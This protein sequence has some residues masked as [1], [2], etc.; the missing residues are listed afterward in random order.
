MRCK[1]TPPNAAS[2][3]QEL[4]RLSLFGFYAHVYSV[5]LAT[6]RNKLMQ[7]YAFTQK[8][9]FS[10]I[11]HG[12]R[13]CVRMSDSLLAAEAASSPHRQLACSRTFY[14]VSP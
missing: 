12:M 9:L 11:R 4:N 6:A 5:A 13:V 1:Q 3:K 8:I 10:A 7:F 14:R 2:C